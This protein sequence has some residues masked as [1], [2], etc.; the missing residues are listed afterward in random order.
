MITHSIRLAPWIIVA[1][2]G[3]GFVL[4]LALLAAQKQFPS[5]GTDRALDHDKSALTV[6]SLAL[7]LL[8]GSAL[9]TAAV[10]SI[11]QGKVFKE[12]LFT[13]GPALPGLPA[14]EFSIYVDR[15]AAF[16]LLLIGGLSCC[17][18]IFS[19][20]YLCDTHGRVANL[21]S[22]DSDSSTELPNS[23]AVDRQPYRYL[24]PSDRVEVAAFYNLFVLAG[25]AFTV[26]SNIFFLILWLEVSTLAF[27]AL[28]LHK[29]FE[30]PASDPSGHEYRQ[31]VKLY[32]IANHLGGMMIAVA[33]LVLVYTFGQ[34][35]SHGFTLNLST[36]YGTAWP[37]PPALQSAVFLLLFAGFGIKAGIVP[38]HIWVAIAHPSSPT[39]TH[40]MSLGIMIKLALYGMI[41][42]FFLLLR[43]FPWWWG[44]L[45]I[46]VASLTAVVSVN[47]ALHGRTLKEAFAD[48]SVE[49]IGII[50]AGIGLALIFSSQDLARIPVVPELAGLALLAA[51]F[52]LLNHTVFKGLLYLCTGAIEYLTGTVRF[53]ELGG[54]IHHFGSRRRAF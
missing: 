26:S 34:A 35:S 40:A 49:N 19:L 10:V 24:I 42:V 16:F 53:D 31:S 23:A 51:L 22:G 43:P 3:L 4:P 37:G 50:L 39:N 20:G 27:G 29:H 25:A 15:L 1:L 54:L 14:L 8:G 21:K 13:S 30:D 48:H 17:V 33:L 6:L 11:I 32:L 44:M 9:T 12:V 36:W 47:N 41:R 18:S 38:F 2:F 7:A 5:N 52:H 28:I 46:V 45:V